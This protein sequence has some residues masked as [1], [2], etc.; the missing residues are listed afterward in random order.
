MSPSG[1]LRTS[2]TPASIAGLVEFLGVEQ[3]FS[4]EPLANHTT[5]RIGGPADLLYQAKTVAQL[6]RAVSAARELEVPVTMLG[7]GSNVLVSDKGIRG[8]VIKNETREII[9]G[10]VLPAK[11]AEGVDKPRWQSDKT[12]GTL[13]IWIMMRPKVRG[14]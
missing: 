1:V 3:T 5:L 2:S 4:D 6:V 11:K 10:E 12:R 7:W 8:L 9:I 14:S 13:M